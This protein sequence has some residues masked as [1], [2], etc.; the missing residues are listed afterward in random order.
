MAHNDQA[1]GCRTG[2][3]D[4][5]LSMLGQYTGADEEREHAN[6]EMEA[7]SASEAERGDAGTT[8]SGA[9]EGD[10]SGREAS[11]ECERKKRNQTSSATPNMHS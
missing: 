7:P 1:R 8:T 3:D 10:P 6:D 2:G 4:L 5:Y 9:E 11:R